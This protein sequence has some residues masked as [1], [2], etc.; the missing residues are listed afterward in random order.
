MSDI[1]LMNSVTLTHGGS[2]VII[3]NR[4]TLFSNGQLFYCE[5]AILT[6]CV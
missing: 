1:K 2:I 4:V 5:Y 6:V 3:S